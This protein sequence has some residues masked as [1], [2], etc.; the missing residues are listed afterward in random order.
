M[1]EQ[2]GTKTIY[3]IA[4]APEF[5]ES[6]SVRIQQELY[7]HQN[8]E[9]SPDEGHLFISH[10]ADAYKYS[11]FLLTHPNYTGKTA[12]GIYRG[13]SHAGIEAAY[14][15]P[16]RRVQTPQGQLLVYPEIV[17]VLGL[18]DVLEGWVLYLLDQG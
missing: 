5:D 6:K 16:Q 8:S 4:Q 9:T 2:I 10:H 1:P 17:F 15:S 11:L 7:F 18:N 3:E 14:G 12:R 13:A